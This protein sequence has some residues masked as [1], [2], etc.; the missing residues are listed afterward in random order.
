MAGVFTKSVFGSLTVN[1]GSDGEGG[2]DDDGNEP[3]KKKK[4]KFSY[5]SSALFFTTCTNTTINFL[6]RRCWE[7]VN[8]GTNSVSSLS[9]K[10]GAIPKTR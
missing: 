5:T 6:L 1:P 4:K 3:N 10:L 9:P 8:I 7:D 2:G